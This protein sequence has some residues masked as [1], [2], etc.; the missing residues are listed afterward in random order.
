[1]R[2]RPAEARTDWK[3]GHKKHMEA[4]HRKGRTNEQ[5]RQKVHNRILSKDISNT[6][7]SLQLGLRLR[8][9]AP[10]RGLLASPS[11]REGKEIPECLA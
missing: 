9:A 6:T 7:D 3:A 2:L 10:R 11:G 1:M 8:E 5:R 4:T